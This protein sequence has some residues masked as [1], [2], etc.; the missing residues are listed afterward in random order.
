MYMYMYMYTHVHVHVYT[1]TFVY[2]NWWYRCS[3]KNIIPFLELPIAENFCGT[4]ILSNP[5][6]ITILVE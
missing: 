3:D 4:K 6:T 5:A 1:C 2:G